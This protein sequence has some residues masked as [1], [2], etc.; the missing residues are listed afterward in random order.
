MRVIFDGSAAGSG[1]TRSQIM[2]SDGTNVINPGDPATLDAGD[3][4]TTPT[5]D[6]TSET[7]HGL[8]EGVYT[9]TINVRP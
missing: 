1:V 7:F 9:C 2:C 5:R 3:N 6:D 4:P 8:T